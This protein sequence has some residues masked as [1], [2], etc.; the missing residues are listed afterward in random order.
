MSHTSG[1]WPTQ[2]ASRL[3]ITLSFI[4]LQSVSGLFLK[5][6]FEMEDTEAQRKAVQMVT[7]GPIQTIFISNE[8]LFKW[9]QLHCNISCP[10]LDNLNLGWA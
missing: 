8:E 5:A 9:I 2:P 10:S 1:L 7:F 4:F 3:T 6:L